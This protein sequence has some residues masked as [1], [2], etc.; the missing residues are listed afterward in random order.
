MALC[1]CWM[2]LAALAVFAPNVPLTVLL[3][4][5]G[6][7]GHQG[8]SANLLTSVSDC[9]PTPAVATVIGIGQ[10]LASFG[11]LLF[12][13]LLTGF[14]VT[15]YGY[16]PVFMMFGSAHLIGFASVHFLMR[17]LRP[18]PEREVQG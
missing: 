4:S 18:I 15:H 5:L 11:G 7:A 14:L 2:P 10:W 6:T 1:V 9:Y 12:S 17:D 13:S 8:W 16:V 3:I